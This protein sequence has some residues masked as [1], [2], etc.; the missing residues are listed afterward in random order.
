MAIG[1]FCSEAGPIGN[2]D[3]G[4]DAR[5]RGTVV[6]HVVAGMALAVASLCAHAETETIVQQGR[7]SMRPTPL[8]MSPARIDLSEKTPTVMVT[9]HNDD[10]RSAMLVRMQPMMWT[11]DGIAPHYELTP[12][13]V[14]VPATFV[15][16]A[17]AT[18]TV[19][20]DLLSA[21]NLAS[22]RNFQLFWQAQAEPAGSKMHDERAAP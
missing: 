20:V 12:D 8:S 16:P 10:L 21:A 4:R 22:G 7:A 11:Q 1:F 9:V 18:Q 3:A 5:R 14:A 13:V 17:G 19:E 6:V 15:V 2:Q